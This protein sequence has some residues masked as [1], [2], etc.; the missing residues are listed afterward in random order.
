MSRS[1]SSRCS[2]TH[3]AQS[4]TLCCRGSAQ[5][6]PFRSSSGGQERSAEMHSTAWVSVFQGPCLVLLVA[7][8]KMHSTV[9]VISLAKLSI[10]ASPAGYLSGHGL[11][12]LQRSVHTLS[13]G[14]NSGVRALACNQLSNSSGGTFSGLCHL[15]TCQCTQASVAAMRLYRYAHSSCS[16]DNERPPTLPPPTNRRGA[17]PQPTDKLPGPSLGHSPCGSVAIVPLRLLLPLS[18][19]RQHDGAATCGCRSHGP[20][21]RHLLSLCVVH[22]DCCVCCCLVCCCS[23]C[24]NCCAGP[25][26]VKAAIW[27]CVEHMYARKISLLYAG[28]I[29]TPSEV[30][31]RRVGQDRKGQGRAGQCAV[32]ATLTLVALPTSC[33]AHRGNSSGRVFTR[34]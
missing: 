32:D 6:K 25:I 28:P 7:I 4:C 24:Q 26:A 20:L 21:R 8:H 23:C 33:V 29:S 10:A 1:H 19:P 17:R 16:T 30:R 22:L 2:T 31:R 9:G 14:C 27:T 15:V 13:H 18:L 3:W 12:V 5:S 34:Q 11:A